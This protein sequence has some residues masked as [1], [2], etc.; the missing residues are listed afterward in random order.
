MTMNAPKAF[1]R[2]TRPQAKQAL[3]RSGYILESRLETVLLKPDRAYYVEANS[4]IPDADTGK[5]LELDIYAMTATH[6]GPETQDLIFGVLLIE[7]VNNPQAIAFITKQP[8]LAFLHH[9]EVKFAGLPA[10]IPDKDEPDSWQT[11]PDYLQMNKYHHYCKGR[12]ATQFCSFQ[13]KKGKQEWMATHDEAHFESFRKLCT[14]VD[15]FADRHFKKWVFEDHE[16]VNL[17]F[18]YPLVVLQ[19]DLLDVRASAKSCSLRPAH[20][21]QYRR[22]TIVSG[23]EQN[24]QIDVVTEQFLPT[25]LD[26]IEGELSKTARLLRRRHVAVRDAIDRIAEQAS[27]LPPEDRRAAMTTE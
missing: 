25:Y 4:A 13:Q 9:Q 2:I 18:Y 21:I 19:G 7:C 26:I 14:A 12:V 6:T 22:S 1:P 8:Q 15:Y 20:H 3:L 11:L 23:E 17:E 5:S 27:G 24:Y 10:K 16:N